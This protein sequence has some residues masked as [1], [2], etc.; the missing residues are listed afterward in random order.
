VQDGDALAEGELSV[1]VA[2]AQLLLVVECVHGRILL[3]VMLQADFSLSELYVWVWSLCLIRLTCC[4]IGAGIGKRRAGELTGIV[5]PSRRHRYPRG[6]VAAARMHL[7]AAYV[8]VCLS[9]RFVCI[10]E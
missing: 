3:E 7:A 8:C 2:C 5:Q 6:N 10:C 4:R 9:V 1:E